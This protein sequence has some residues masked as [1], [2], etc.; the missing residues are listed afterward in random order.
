MQSPRVCNHAVVLVRSSPT[1]PREREHR[2]RSIGITEMSNDSNGGASVQWDYDGEV[3]RIRMR[4]KGVCWLMKSGWKDVQNYLL[5][6]AR[7]ALQ[8]QEPIH[9][10]LT[11]L[12]SSQ[13]RS[14]VQGALQT[15]EASLQ[16][17]MLL[18]P[19]PN[20]NLVA[21]WT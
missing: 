6:R 18:P 4:R 1:C 9:R 10:P 11:L 13:V 7:S 8:L 16:L 19:W 3:S 21:G 12:R 20:Q 17:E 15:A 5:K 2:S 14:D